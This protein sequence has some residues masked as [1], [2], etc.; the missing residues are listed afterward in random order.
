[1]NES[2]ETV[3]SLRVL[4][5]DD[6]EASRNDL[7]L[8]VEQL[9]LRSS[10]AASGA[11][12][13]DILAKDPP[14]L[15]LLDLLM[16]GM[17]GFE[18]ARRLRAS[19]GPRW[20]PL[21][22]TSSLPGEL[23]FVRAVESGADDY[24]SRP[25]DPL[26][27]QAKL[28]HYGRVGALQTRL[29]VLASRQQHILDSLPDAVLTV[30]DRGLVAD[31]NLAASLA[32]GGSPQASLRERRCEDVLGLKLERLRVDATPELQRFD[33]SRL[34][35]EVRSSDW[36]DGGRRYCTLVLRDI[37]EARRIERMKD[38][39]I[40][41]V[42]HELRT[43]LTSVLG[44]LGLLAAGAAGPL[45]AAALPLAEAAQRNGQRLSQLIDDILD[46]TKL[47]GQRL[48]IKTMLT[49]IGR[50][51]Q[52]AHTA[53]LGYA[54]RS[55]VRLAT[56]IDPEAAPLEPLLDANRFLQV[57]ANL[58]SNAVKHSPAGGTVSVSLRRSG[59]SV[60][61]RVRDSGPGIDPAFRSQL[62]QKFSQA[63]PSDHRASGGT[64]L[65]LYIS[66]MLVERMGGT[67]DVEPSAGIGAVFCVSL[68]LA[69]VPRRKPWVL[70]VDSDLDARQRAARWLEPWCD[71]TALAVLP[72]R[73]PADDATPPIIVADT[74]A[75]GDA[76]RFCAELRRRAA[77]RMVLLHSDSVDA[78]F[79]R[80]VGA[81]W[82]RKSSV[83]QDD[84]VH[85]VRRALA[86]ASEEASG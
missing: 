25:V 30:D 68:P 51:V 70:I 37:T 10:G 47:E 11:Q 7:R 18:L 33:G 20:L 31:A 12:A 71:V 76:E 49:P 62:F 23:A 29:K 3:S 19:C 53:N 45:P 66:R 52:E 16:P 81:E 65:G 38:E 21:I 73:P 35:V 86:A 85:A 2:L 64:G 55:G 40:A 6:I 84:L 14:D 43:P 56:D 26:L 63:D 36:V 1:M 72:P 57:M 46:L 34:P 61:V 41:G 17:D 59:R 42:S 50:L 48:S 27:L 32:F 4:V 22:A 75:Q 13:L 15:V 83:G 82:L 9:G 5:V 44:A 79:A 74:R 54:E 24:L 28:R 8:M 80:S 60:Q 77:G 78:G 58:L 69:Q 67:I 39:F